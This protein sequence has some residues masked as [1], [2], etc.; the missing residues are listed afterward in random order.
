MR[1]DLILKPLKEKDG[2]T[3][4]LKHIPKSSHKTFTPI[5][6]DNRDLQSFN[7]MIMAGEPDPDT[8][9]VKKG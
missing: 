8:I 2:C 6:V 5:P 4:W 9:Y 1:S 3:S 7:D